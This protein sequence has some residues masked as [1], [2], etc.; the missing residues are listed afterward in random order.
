MRACA[1]LMICIANMMWI[2]CTYSAEITEPATSDATAQQNPRPQDVQPTFEESKE[3]DK[4]VIKPVG[5]FFL[6]EI[7]EFVADS[8]ANAGKLP[9]VLG[10]NVKMG[11]EAEDR[12]GTGTFNK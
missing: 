10:E 1:V 6:L 8:A 11:L 5:E 7:P 12:D 2:P 9:E 4:G 3:L